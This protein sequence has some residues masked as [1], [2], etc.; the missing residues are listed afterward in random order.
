L[1]KEKKKSSIFHDHTDSTIK[2]LIINIYN[3]SPSRDVGMGAH[4]Q[5]VAAKPSRQ[6]DVGGDPSGVKGCVDVC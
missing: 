2:L 6:G 1:R 5:A 3:I 4:G